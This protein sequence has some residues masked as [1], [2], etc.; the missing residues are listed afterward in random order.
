MPSTG[1]KEPAVFA[2]RN[3]S[4][5]FAGSSVSALGDQFTIIALPW[6]VLKLTGNTAALGIVLAMMAV[7]RAVFMLIGGAIVD[8]FS[9]R[10]VLLY[11]R[12]VNALCI[13]ILAVLVLNGIV[14]MWM[15]CVL[16]LG[17]GLATAFAYPAGSAILPQ[18]LEKEQLRAANALMMG[19]RQLSM[20]VGPVI[21][22]F[23][24]ALGA[25]NVTA[26]LLADAHGIGIAFC[27]DAF[28]F[29]VSLISL[30]SIRVSSDF[31]APTVSNGVFHSIKEGIRSV[32]SDAPLRA[33]MFYGV[34]LTLFVIG[35]LQ[36][37]L[38]VLANSRLHLGAASL[39]ILMT[40]NG[41]GVLVGS[42]LSGLAAKLMRGRLG[43]MVL[44]FDCLNGLVLASLALVQATPQAAML[45][46]CIGGLGG[47]VQVSTI[48]WIQQRVPKE[49]MGRTMSIMM[50]IVMGLGPLSGAV[51]GILL[52]V[53][54]LPALFAGAGLTLT[55]T[56][57][58]FLSNSQ[59]RN[60]RSVPKE[61]KSA[62]AAA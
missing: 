15:I 50:F 56:A 24:I 27:I 26:N 7:P 23:V 57:L 53:I 51:A 60:I 29:M 33:F 2:N 13:T 43:I 11:S 54:S 22:G 48:A 47:M 25:K 12:A 17:I 35:P 52:R 34:F 4:L 44:T 61:P 18:L 40:S 46:S 62:P 8:R 10:R 55:V 59:L 9:P 19:M 5:L 14:H 36:V 37:G 49:L 45:L 31:V 21:A 16:A 38:P 6:L 42:A 41:I 20:I 1:K 58:V 28:S 39:G 3:F 30:W 32:W